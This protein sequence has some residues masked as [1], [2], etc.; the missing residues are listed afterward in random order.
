MEFQE[1]EN[2]AC[3]YW[4]KELAERAASI[5][6]ISPLIETQ[7]EF[8]SILTI[9]TNKPT[10]CFDAVRL[11][12][13]ISPNLFVK[14]LMVLSDIGGERLHRFFKDLDKI[15]PDRIMEFNIGN[16]SYSYQFNSNRAWTTKNL[17]V[18]KSRLLQPVSDFTREMLD[19]CMLILWGGN[20]INN[21]NLPTEIENNC[22]LGN[23][24]G[25]KEAIEQL[26][27][28]RYIMVI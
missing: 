14:H 27:K 1:L 25:N 26:L 19:V 21:T 10:S 2:S 23:L 17:N 24:I 9:S 22:I 8:L 16:N 7:D 20:T 13:K 28:E 5:S 18:E 6:A 3:L 4:P 15:Y 11:C 12:N